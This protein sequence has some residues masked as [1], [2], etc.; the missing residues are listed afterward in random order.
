MGVELGPHR[1]ELKSA[2]VKV[3]SV[4]FSQ[5]LPRLHITAMGRS[6]EG[7]PGAAPAHRVRNHEEQ[8]ATADFKLKLLSLP[9]R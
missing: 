2:E 7:N 5:T 4:S 8:F 9:C 6:S 1:S 3:S